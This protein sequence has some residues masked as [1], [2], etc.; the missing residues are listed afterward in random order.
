MHAHTYE[1]TSSPD[2]RRALVVVVV[3]VAAAAAADT[4]A[5][6]ADATL[7]YCHRTRAQSATTTARV[8]SRI[9]HTHICAL[10]HRARVRAHAYRDC[11][12]R[13]VSSCEY[14]CE[15]ST[16]CCCLYVQHYAMCCREVDVGGS[17]SQIHVRGAT[18]TEI[19]FFGCDSRA[20]NIAY[21]I[22]VHIYSAH[23]ISQICI[24][25]CS[26]W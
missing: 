24:P 11:S 14:L 5:D 25:T 9:L 26:C 21:S 22:Y 2:I 20:C 13:G 8:S 6:A 16:I 7:I 1:H 10:E 15:Y 18:H 3:D 19:H 23:L 4:T 17:K 12:V